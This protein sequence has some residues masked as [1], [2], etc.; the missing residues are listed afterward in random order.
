MV[1]SA[2]GW[3]VLRH[4]SSVG[5][6]GP[7]QLKKVFPNC[8]PAVTMTPQQIVL[9]LSRLKQY[10]LFIISHSFVGLESRSSSYG[11]SDLGSILSVQ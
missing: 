8:P 7:N 3:N 10:Y 4:G 2:E 9:K 5:Q 1:T 6:F 11:T